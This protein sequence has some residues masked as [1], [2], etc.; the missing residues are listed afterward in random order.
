MERPFG[1]A[2]VAA[3]ALVLTGA[4]APAEANVR[5]ITVSGLAFA[6]PPERLKVGDAVMW[7]NLDLFEHT[8]T[9]RNGEFDVDLKPGAKVKVVL[10]QAGTIDYYCR[11]HPGMTGKL[12]V[13]G[14]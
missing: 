11:F 12:V 13:V 14:R 2:A 5:I 8:A 1:V 6:P 10:K 4:A 7:V 9:A 3:A